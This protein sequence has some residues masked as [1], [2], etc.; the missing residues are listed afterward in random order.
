MAGDT[1]FALSSGSPPAALAVVRISGPAAFDALS[2]LGGSLPPP[3]VARLRTLH[4]PASG[5]VLDRAL[6]LAL[7][8]PNNATGE[9]CA[10][11]HLHGGRAVIAAVESALEALPD[12]RRAEA[13]EFTRRAFANGR[14]DLAEAE[15]LADLLAAE[16][17]LQ[18]R[19]A[20]ALAGGALSHAV[21][22]WLQRLL[23]L[24]AMVEASLD[25]AD[26]DD[27]GALP[28]DLSQGIGSLAEDLA[29]WLAVPRAE[30]LR[31]GYRIVIA[32]PPNAGKSSL[33]NAL[34]EE[35]AA[36]ATPIA[37]T[38]RDLLTRSVAISGVP[39]VFTDTA[40]LRAQT[41]DPIESIGIERA[42]DAIQTADL[43]MWLGGQGEGPDGAI[44]ID[45]MS[46]LHRPRKSVCCWRVSAKTGKGI[47]DLRAEL[48]RRAR[49]AMPQAG[50][51][52]VSHH[53][54]RLLGD[55]KRALSRAFLH[56]DPLLIAEELRVARLA[57][58]RLT[59]RA[60]TDDMLDGLFGRFCIGK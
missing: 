1:I 35:E 29:T 14:L 6:V 9:D 34:V 20:Q 8:G 41:S 52:A 5:D 12:L 15:G 38:T 55:A 57:F 48:L 60:A 13:G 46:D 53:Q 36:I 39:L 27:V 31:D 21:D 7:P 26:E 40:G 25:F 19:N 23:A 22:G 3:R 24:S 47:G 58:D 10:E 28:P 49:S 17:K 50:Q 45:P 4:D 37:G 43:V 59:G 18:L 44:E 42:K 32:G 11:L 30:T 16:T 56:Q 51:V 2:A 54:G 33:F